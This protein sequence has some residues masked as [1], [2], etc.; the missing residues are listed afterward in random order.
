MLAYAIN[1]DLLSTNAPRV[2]EQL[3]QLTDSSP[4]FDVL[5]IDLRSAAMVDSIGLNLLVWA[6]EIGAS[7]RRC[8]A[9]TNHQRRRRADLPLHAS[10]LLH[11]SVKK[12]ALWGRFQ[13]AA[14]F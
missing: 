11:R 8:S 4:S 5:E 3:S 6:L 2:R 13:P 9:R 10:Q 14:D 7:E 12:L 1:G